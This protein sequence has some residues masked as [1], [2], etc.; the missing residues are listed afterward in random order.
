MKIRKSAFEAAILKARKRLSKLDDEL[1]ITYRLAAS[2]NIKQAY[3]MALK[4]EDTSEN[5]TLLMRSIPAYT[6]N[7]K[8]LEDATEVMRVNVPIELGYTREGWFVLR[9]PLLLPKKSEGSASYIRSF[10]YPAMKEFFENTYPIR[11]Q[12][13]V[14]VYRH[15]YD[16]SRPERAYRDHD[17]IE[18]NMVTDVVAMYVMED[19][20]PLNCRHYYCSAKGTKERT[21]VYVIPRTEFSDFLFVEHT[22]PDMGVKLYE[23]RSKLDEK[24]VSKPCEF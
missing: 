6:G 21:E 22:I 2:G 11:Y 16:E 7:P 5:L 10:L 15:V 20:S 3:D 4:A 23:I 9:M 12:D 1:Q 14:L 13:C 17:N 24:E 8:A 18:L 19:D